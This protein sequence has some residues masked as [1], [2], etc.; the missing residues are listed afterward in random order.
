MGDRGEP[1]IVT[2]IVMIHHVLQKATR[3]V[4]T[5]HTDFGLQRSKT[6]ES[7]ELYHCDLPRTICGLP[8]NEAGFGI[9][10]THNNLILHVGGVV[11]GRPTYSGGCRQK[12]TVFFRADN[13]N[14]HCRIGRGDK[15]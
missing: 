15:A 6:G 12:R 2:L 10:Q 11:N 1:L 9:G 14:I 4:S 13:R 7:L 5:P 3:G 8:Q